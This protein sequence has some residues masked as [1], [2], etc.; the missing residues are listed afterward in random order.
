MS[1]H[2]GVSLSVAP[3][4]ATLSKVNGSKS[5]T[6]APWSHRGLWLFGNTIGRI[7]NVGWTLTTALP[8]S[9]RRARRVFLW[10]RAGGPGEIRGGCHLTPNPPQEQ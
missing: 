7:G 6:R 1:S 5:L 3:L 10:C 9:A 8:A 2:I 4:P